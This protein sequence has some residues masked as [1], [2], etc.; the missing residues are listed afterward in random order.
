[1]L[2]R[3]LREL[4][5]AHEA[6]QQTV[7]QCNQR[8]AQAAEALAALDG[9]LCGNGL[10]PAHVTQ[11]ISGGLL[12]RARACAAGGPVLQ[13]LALAQL[14]SGLEALQAVGVVEA[15]VEDKWTTGSPAALAACKMET[16]TK[17]ARDVDGAGVA[18]SAGPCDHYREP[19]DYNHG[20]GAPASQRARVVLCGASADV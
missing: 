8:K 14:Q 5:L 19:R 4:Q 20:G 3:G 1:M 12:G 11:H 13:A 7:T 18:Q 15:I 9:I 10:V 17:R 6:V 16:G 2:Q